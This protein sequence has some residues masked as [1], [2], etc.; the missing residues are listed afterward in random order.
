MYLFVDAEFLPLPGDSHMLLSI[1]MCGPLGEEFYGELETAVDASENDFVVEHVLP[2]LNKGLGLRGS[3][4][5]I[6]SALVEWL[7]RFEGERIEL[8]YDFHVDRLAFEELVDS[9]SLSPRFGFE[10]VHVAYLLGDADA[11]LAAD[12]C[13]AELERSRGLRRH[14]ALADAIALRARFNSAHS[15]EMDDPNGLTA[16]MDPRVGEGGQRPSC[17]DDVIDLREASRLLHVSRTA[18]RKLVN[19]GALDVIRTTQFGDE[20]VSRSAVLEHRAAMKRRQARGLKQM[21]EASTKLGLYDDE[22]LLA[23][24]PRRGSKPQSTTAD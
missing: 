24:G 14:H 8:C 15:I 18:I 21:M 4:E 23:Q 10:A 20:R 17:I 16:P 19:A 22:L 5:T 13:W 6:R 12:A 2:Q 9:A 3:Q 11:A 1:G 7:R